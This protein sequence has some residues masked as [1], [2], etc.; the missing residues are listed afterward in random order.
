MLTARNLKDGK[1]EDMTYE[2]W[3]RQGVSTIGAKAGKT[4]S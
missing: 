1:K 2:A 3:K 4:F